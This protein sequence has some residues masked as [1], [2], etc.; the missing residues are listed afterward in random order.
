MQ[1]EHF[2]QKFALRQVRMPN[3]DTDAGQ[4]KE[5]LDRKSKA[6]IALEVKS[7]VVE[8]GATIGASPS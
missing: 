8:N 5:H 2:Q 3:N 6:G 1:S 4:R 7:N